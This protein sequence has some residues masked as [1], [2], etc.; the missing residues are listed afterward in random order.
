[1]TM[2][3][4]NPV[5]GGAPLL[6]D[7]RDWTRGRAVPLVVVALL[8]AVNTG[9]FLWCGLGHH[10]RPL[11]LLA[12]DLAHLDTG[13]LALSLV[14]VHGPAQLVVGLPV[15][16]AVLCMATP[17][18]GNLRTLLVG[19]ASAVVGTAVGLASCML[20][21]RLFDGA[22]GAVDMPFTLT[23]VTLVVGALMAATAFDGELW[24]R[25][26]RIVGYSVILV[27]LLYGGN[28]GDY[29]TLMAAVA[30]QLI[31]RLLAG[32]PGVN[33]VWRRQRPPYCERRK[34]VGAVGLVLAAAPF[35]AATSR[36]RVG[37]LMA[38]AITMAPGTGTRERLALCTGVGLR[39]DAC[40]A[41]LEAA[42][43]GAAGHGVAGFS[44]ANAGN[45]LRALAVMMALT[46]VMAVIAV[47]LFLG[48]RVAA[49]AGIACYGLMAGIELVRAFAQSP[50]PGSAVALPA[51]GPF[52]AAVGVAVPLAFM[53][54][55]VV[56]WR[57]FAVGRMAGIVP[58]DDLVE[59]GGSS[60]SFMTTWSGNR[61]WTSPTGRSAVAF[62]VRNGVALTTTGPFGDP[63]EWADD[64]AA[65]PAYCSANGWTPAFYAV[66]RQ[67]HDRLA[68]AGWHSLL[69]G[70]E[71][72]VDPRTWKTTGKK[73]Q[74]IRTAINKARKTGI[75]DVLCR[76]DELSDD[77]R[78]QIHDICE[79]WSGDKPLPEMKFTLGGFDELHDSRVLILYAIDA[80]GTV[81][82][83]TSWLPTW[84]DGRV[85][86]WTLDVMRHRDDAPNGIM[87]LLIARMAQRM[88][89][90]GERDPEHAVEFVSLSAAP[91]SGLD[92][93]DDEDGRALQHALAAMAEL[94]EPAYGFKSLYRFK[95]KFQPST[96]PVYLCYADSATLAAIGLAVLRSYLPTLTIP[97]LF[98]LLPTLKPK[99][100][101]TEKTE[102]AEKTEKKTGKTEKAEQTEK[103]GKTATA[104]Q[105]E[106]SGK[107]LDRLS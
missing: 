92:D 101:K 76:F 67:A 15:V 65:F 37:P 16:A 71:M 53:L 13:R 100:E 88:H 79:Q 20:V 80:D 10:G 12:T 7:L 8:L 72:I 105:A 49:V 50:A 69:V 68:A 82:G 61:Y 47:G 51:P 40:R 57:S 91:L 87:E 70:Q 107:G 56:N 90:D 63:D 96:E 33:A 59:T 11:G 21:A 2:H 45:A 58:V 26:V 84:R 17:K 54:A 6:H 78:R 106:T 55:I 43:L 27:V 19:V 81:L 97:Q 102:K 93:A 38:M 30:G 32:R 73:W 104:E 31:G 36:G 66:G 77:V 60:M 35:M 75:D 34:L 1:M 95:R 18:L 42:S 83:V 5:A 48:R 86:G 23:P 64:L 28:P 29:C 85:V 103:T 14:L 52:A 9:W 44:G 25:R 39:A 99:K 98:A 94:L 62:R 89:D 74:D 3:T 4:S 46:A 41:G 22:T 24:R